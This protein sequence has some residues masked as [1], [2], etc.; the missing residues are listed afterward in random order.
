[1]TYIKQALRAE[2]LPYAGPGCAVVAIGSIV[3]S[4]HEYT[5]TGTKALEENL[6]FPQ[7]ED[8]A[9]DA[10]DL[11]FLET[12]AANQETVDYTP[13]RQQYNNRTQLYTSTVLS[14]MSE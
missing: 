1:M 3:D 13:P 7:A 10:C 14:S 6:Q 5:L 8:L 9:V 2:G 12:L 11:D 4:D